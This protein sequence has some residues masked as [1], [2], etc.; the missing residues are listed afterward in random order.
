MEPCLSFTDLVTRYGT[1]ASTSESLY[2]FAPFHSVFL[3]H[4]AMRALSPKLKAFAFEGFAHQSN[5]LHLW[6]TKLKFDGL[7]GSSIF[8]S[9]FYNTVYLGG[10][11]CD[12]AHFAIIFIRFV[13]FL[14]TILQICSAHHQGDQHFV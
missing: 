11:K 14:T 7:K 12:F 5:D 6:Q 2:V 3:A 4:A 10:C 8:P 9:H 13:E 1:L